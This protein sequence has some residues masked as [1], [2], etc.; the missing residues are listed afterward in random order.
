MELLHD[1]PASAS[2]VTSSQLVAWAVP[3]HVHHL[4]FDKDAAAARKNPAPL[5]L[6]EA[7]APLT[8]GER[9]AELQAKLLLYT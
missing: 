8:E 7:V 6:A 2:V 5:E 3:K 4:V 9:L 1:C